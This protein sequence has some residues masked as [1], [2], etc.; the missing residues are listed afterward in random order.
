MATE[1][2]T[3]PTPAST[4]PATAPATPPATAPATPPATEEAEGAGSHRKV[5]VEL[6][7]ERKARQK[8]TEELA[9]MKARHQTSEEK[10]IEAAKKSGREEALLEVN[11]RIVKSEIRAAAAAKV[12]DP[13]D[14][15]TF[16]G[17]LDRFIVKGEVDTK[18]ISSAIDEL[19]KAKP[20]LAVIATGKPRPLPGGGATP[21]SGVSINDA[22]RQKAGRG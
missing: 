16:L 22:I 3:P 14:A 7:D 4:P 12:S 6:A 19:V 18:A 15:V 1:P 13:E 9:E 17:N 5:L 21:Q 2:T 8:L 10:A 20:Y 11:G